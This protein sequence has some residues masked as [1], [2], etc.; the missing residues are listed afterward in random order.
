MN[1]PVAAEPVAVWVQAPDPEG[2]VVTA[3]VAET[4]QVPVRVP[5]PEE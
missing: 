2:A 3:S 4:E 5:A 1:G